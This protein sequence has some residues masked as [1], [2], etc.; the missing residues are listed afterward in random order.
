MSTLSCTE[1]PSLPPPPALSGPVTTGTT[2]DSD[3]VVDDVDDADTTDG[4]DTDLGASCSPYSDPETECGPDLECDLIDEICVPAQGTAAI[5]ADCELTSDGDSC[6]PG[7]TCTDGRCLAP[8]DPLAGDGALGSC[9]D[10]S[11]ICVLDLGRALGVC[12]ETC[13]LIDQLCLR[14][15]DGCYR[16][17]TNNS[18]AA[19]CSTNTADGFI[20]DGCSADGDCSPRLLCTAARLHVLPCAGQADSCCT[21]VCDAEQL[22][23][24]GSEPVCYQL[25]IPGDESVGFCGG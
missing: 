5:D 7:L 14:D 23:C 2:P 15:S 8:C 18:M 19:V 24:L 4:L 3:D 20:G 9:T 17:T 6:A 22:P 25:A 1:A 21:N 13:S 10:E 12:R 11:R 16:G